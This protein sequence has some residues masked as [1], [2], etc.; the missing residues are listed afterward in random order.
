MEIQVKLIGVSLILLALVHFIFPKYFDWKKD[1][2]SL[3]LI[4]REMMWIHTFFIAL[5][6]LLIGL[7]CISSVDQLLYTILGKRISLGI[8]VFWTCRL[9]IQFFG[10]S[11]ELWQGKIF[12]TLVHI[13]F[14]LLWLYLSVFFLYIYFK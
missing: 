8:G 3:S 10:Y 6:V 11:K 13:L 2:A 14:S 9:I 1:L 12:E 4:N 5:A 7:L